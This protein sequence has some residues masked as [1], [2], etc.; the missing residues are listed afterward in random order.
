[1]WTGVVSKQRMQDPLR[2]SS[3]LIFRGGGVFVCDVFYGGG[4][5]IVVVEIS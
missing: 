4:C 1:M 2:V 5:E 3:V